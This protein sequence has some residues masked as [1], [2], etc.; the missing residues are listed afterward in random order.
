VIG[1]VEPVALAL[2]SAEA[3]TSRTA[4]RGAS[5]LAG[6]SALAARRLARRLK[7]R[8][9]AASA[10]GCRVP[11]RR[12]GRACADAQGSLRRTCLG[13]CQ[14]F[15]ASSCRSRLPILQL[16]RYRFYFAKL[17]QGDPG[18]FPDFYIALARINLIVRSDL[19][20]CIL[21]LASCIGISHRLHP[22]LL[23]LLGI[24]VYIS[25]VHRFVISQ[26]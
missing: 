20:S 2:V 22:V 21:H 19:A 12:V 9:D 18:R 17:S 5:S 26:L 8:L 13:R 11:A 24:I 15:S 1:T 10:P 6:L 14:H 3:D 7:S 23:P 25:K 4:G 16:E